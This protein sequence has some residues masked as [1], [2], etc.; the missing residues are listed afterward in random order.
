MQQASD[1][2]TRAP[3]AW[4]WIGRA[5]NKIFADGAVARSCQVPPNRLSHPED[6][7]CVIMWCPQC[8]SLA[9]CQRIRNQEASNKTNNILADADFPTIAALAHHEVQPRLHHIHRASWR[10]YHLTDVARSLKCALCTSRASHREVQRNHQSP[11]LTSST[12]N[13]EN[14]APDRPKLKTS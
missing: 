13:A 6:I 3:K 11:R 14:V 7:C 8:G 4:R 10:W 1:L 5:L 9:V 2:P 12:K